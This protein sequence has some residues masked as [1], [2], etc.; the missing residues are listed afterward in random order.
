MRRAWIVLAGC[1]ALGLVG[2]FIVTG[3][4]DGYAPPPAPPLSISDSGCAGDGA[5]INLTAC[6]NAQ[7]CDGGVC[8]LVVSGTASG[9]NFALTGAVAACQATCQGLAVQLCNPAS[10]AGECG[11]SSTCDTHSCGFSGNDVVL[12]ACSG[13][14]LGSA[15]H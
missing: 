4:S 1:A 14:V 9:T 3:N 2:C 8:C 15:C 10:D 6:Q 7:E 13:L 5:C 11:Q 12:N